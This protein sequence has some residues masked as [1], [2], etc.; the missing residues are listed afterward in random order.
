MRQGALGCDGGG[1]GEAREEMGQ[2]EE[3]VAVAVRDVD[4]R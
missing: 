2:A 1:G 3:V 4:V